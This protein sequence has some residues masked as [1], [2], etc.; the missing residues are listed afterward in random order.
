MCQGGRGLGRSLTKTGLV[1]IMNEN[2][3]NNRGSIF[4]ARDRS[5]Y[6]KD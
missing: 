6:K 4:P 3:A 2:I 1:L 5:G